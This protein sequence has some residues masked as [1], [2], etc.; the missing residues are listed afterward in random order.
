[1]WTALTFLPDSLVPIL[2]IVVMVAWMVGLLRGGQ[3]VGI[4]AFVVF[5]VP[6]LSALLPEILATLPDW[7]FVV[8]VLAV[9]LTLVRWVLT[10]LI[11][12]EGA[13]TFLGHMLFSL[14]AGLVRLPVRVL[15][16]LIRIGRGAH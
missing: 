16:W 8:I 2:V 10:L 6:F 4:L 15:G 1:M 3:A 5:L 14:V 9:G 12:T 7:L 11:G 13:G